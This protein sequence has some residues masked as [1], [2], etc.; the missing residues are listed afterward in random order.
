MGI[1]GMKAELLKAGMGVSVVCA[2]ALFL[3]C[4]SENDEDFFVQRASAD[5]PDYSSSEKS[6]SS[7]KSAS[8]GSE[9]KKSSGVEE[10]SSGRAGMK[11]GIPE[12]LFP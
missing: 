12:V 4:S 2:C 9:E 10:E 6:S 1:A 8:S 7:G 3:A 11:C 5:G